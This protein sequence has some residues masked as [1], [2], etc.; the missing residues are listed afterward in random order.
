MY[1]FCRFNLKKMTSLLHLWER[2]VRETPSDW[3][4]KL[5]AQAIISF[6]A[7]QTDLHVIAIW[8][9]QSWNINL[10]SFKFKSTTF[11]KLNRV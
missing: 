9:F 8:K 10:E 4:K 11:L 1:H 2:N 3:F 6:D 7:E 5:T